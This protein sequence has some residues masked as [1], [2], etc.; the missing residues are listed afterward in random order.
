MQ[1][2]LF[3]AYITSRLDYHHFLSSGCPKTIVRVGFLGYLSVLQQSKNYLTAF[4]LCCCLYSL[5][6]MLVAYIKLLLPLLVTPG[7][8]ILFL[9]VLFLSS[10]TQPEAIIRSLVVVL[11]VAFCFWKGVLPFHCCACCLN[12]FIKSDNCE[13]RWSVFLKTNTK[14]TKIVLPHT[15]I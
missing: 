1:K 11:L 7:P 12:L 5:L 9:C 6:Y 15:L 4:P 14:S 3:H 13:Q 10:Q 2:K 8:V